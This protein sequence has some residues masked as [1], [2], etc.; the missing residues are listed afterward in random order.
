MF[1]AEETFLNEIADKN[2]TYIPQPRW[3]NLSTGEKY[4]PDFYC[5][6]DNLYIEVIGSRQR[7][8]QLKLKL[9]VVKI[10]YPNEKFLIINVGAW[11]NINDINL[12]NSALDVAEYIKKKKDIKEVKK[13]FDKIECEGENSCYFRNLIVANRRLLVGKGFKPSTLTMWIQGERFPN[14]ANAKKIADVLGVSVKN[15][16]T[17][18]RNK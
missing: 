8:E 11:K 13:N 6:E 15:F 2:K 17:L 9:A 1:R 3:F 18:I 10:E 14:L 7:Y 16:P 4:K 12:D 5:E